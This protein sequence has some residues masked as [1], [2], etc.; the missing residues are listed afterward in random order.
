MSSL[1]TSAVI[2]I[3]SFS[4]YILFNAIYYLLAFDVFFPNMALSSILVFLSLSLVNEGIELVGRRY[5]SVRAGHFG[6][7]SVESLHVLLEVGVALHVVFLHMKRKQLRPIL[8]HLRVRGGAERSGMN[9]L[10]ASQQ[11]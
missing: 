6:G 7:Q 5:W 3:S 1:E 11:A 2:I 9:H 4:K 10:E 8:G